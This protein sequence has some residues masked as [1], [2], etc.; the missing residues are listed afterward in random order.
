MLSRD[1]LKEAVMRR[2]LFLGFLS[3]H[4]QKSGFRRAMLMAT[5]IHTQDYIKY[6][7]FKI[8]AVQPIYGHQVLTKYLL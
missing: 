2:K 6:A 4:E 1:G 3:T 7:Y 5:L 8:M